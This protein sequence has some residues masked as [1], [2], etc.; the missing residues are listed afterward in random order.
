MQLFIELGS[1]YSWALNMQTPLATLFANATRVCHAIL[2]AIA[3][4]I[5]LFHLTAAEEF[6]IPPHPS[7][8][9]KGK[10]KNVLGSG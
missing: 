4:L 5:F 7:R 2:I 3:F 1:G 6:S 10:K 8:A 9:G